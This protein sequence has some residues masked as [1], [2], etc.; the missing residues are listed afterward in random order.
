MPAALELLNGMNEIGA[1]AAVNGYT[2]HLGSKR[3]LTSTLN[4][5]EEEERNE[6]QSS[7]LGRLWMEYGLAGKLCPALSVYL[8]RE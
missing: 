5:V 4:K 8:H 3:V 6:R 1:T 7:T 2:L